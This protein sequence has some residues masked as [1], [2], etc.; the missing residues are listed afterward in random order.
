MMRFA[1]SPK[2]LFPDASKREK[3]ET[4][5]LAIVNNRLTLISGDDTRFSGYKS[6][7]DTTIIDI[8]LKNNGR[9]I[10]DRAPI[11]TQWESQVES[12][13]YFKSLIETL[14]K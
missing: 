8:Q 11:F 10:F 1:E 14:T 3:G 13:W 9:I 7:D 12:R 4:L 5:A 2:Y 6:V